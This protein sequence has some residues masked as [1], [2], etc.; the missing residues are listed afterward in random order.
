F[1]AVPLALGGGTAP[2]AAAGGLMPPR[3]ATVLT[4][5][6]TPWEMSEYLQGAGCEPP[7][8]CEQVLYWWI[9]STPG[10]E[11][12]VDENL[13]NL[14]YAI[15]VADGPKIV[16][17]FSGGARI[18]T[19]WLTEHAAESTIAPDELSFLLLGNGTR[20]H[21][22]LST[23]V[24]GDS[25]VAPPTR[26]E[27]IDVAREYDPIADFPTN[28]F[29]LLAMANALAGF[30]VIHMDYRD[31]DLDDPDNYVWTEN[32]TTYVF[33]PTQNLPLLQPLRNLGLGWVADQWE[34][35]LRAIIDTAYRR[36]Y[37]PAQPQGE[38]G[39]DAL[40]SAAARS[41]VASAGLMSDG[42]DATT[43]V[44]SEG[45]ATDPER[46]TDAPAATPAAAG[47]EGPGPEGGGNDIEADVAGADEAEEDEVEADGA[48]VAEV[49]AESEADQV[50]AESEADQVDAEAD[51][52]ADAEAD[53]DNR[54]QTKQRTGPKHRA[55][56]NGIKKVS[57]TASEATD[58]GDAR[59]DGSSEDTGPASDSDSAS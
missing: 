5:G 6:P 15:D 23:W 31:V 18:A 8:S 19:A 30:N 45:L 59:A 12:G 38:Q 33:V 9:V 3:P 32:N 20:K 58:A 53:G 55:P 49:H 36:T 10:L 28:P 54:A 47:D 57:V 50:H 24:L 56:L 46:A 52:E 48:D 51:S 34:A 27:V 2:A 11:V 22:G 1:A 43:P 17:A 42:G 14:D 44:K 35:P 21:G 25:I 37:L 26:Y 16:Y 4:H 40:G 39:S 29:N 7:R 41:A 13:F